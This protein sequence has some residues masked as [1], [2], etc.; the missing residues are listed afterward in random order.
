MDTEY[1]AGYTLGFM[2]F[3]C[4]PFVSDNFRAGF[5]EGQASLWAAA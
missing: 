2:G 1:Q 5:A 3:A 4:P